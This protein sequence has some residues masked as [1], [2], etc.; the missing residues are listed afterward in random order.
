MTSNKAKAKSQWHEQSSDVSGYP[1][2]LSICESLKLI[3]FYAGKCR[4]RTSVVAYV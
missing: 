4:E 1:D 2:L 3:S